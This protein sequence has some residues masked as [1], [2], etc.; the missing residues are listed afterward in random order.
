MNQAL[1]AAVATRQQ[2]QFQVSIPTSLAVESAC[3]V[4]PE[5]PVT[6]APLTEVKEIWFNLRTLHR[7]LIGSL[8]AEA[9][10]QVMPEQ[11]VPAL[12]EELAILESVLIKASEGRARPV[13][14]LADYSP[15][16]SKFPKAVFKKATTPKQEFAYKV[17]QHSVMGVLQQQ[18]PQ[19]MR[20][21]RYEI[22]GSHPESFIVTHLP[23]DLLARHRFRRLSL[24]ESHTGTIKP[25]PQ[26]SSKLTDGKNLSHIPFNSF[27]L[28]VFGDNG[29]MFSPHLPALRRVVL[30]MAERDHWT[31]LTTMEKIRESIR[32]VTHPA[33]RTA[34]LSML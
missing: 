2:G 31:A 23:V 6:P 8:S 18:P 32:K 28:Q 19:D 11:I 4:Y 17:E 9:R 13:F 25:P 10:N 30:E 15:L 29:H 27:T 34:L 5:R 14:Y 26:W 33:D 22:T 21:Y 16:A 3:G 12:I 24:L 1:E 7:N 20:T